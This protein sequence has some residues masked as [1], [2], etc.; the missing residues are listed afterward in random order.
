ML[1]LNGLALDDQNAELEE[2][3]KEW[4]QA[5][6][7]LKLTLTNKSEIL[8]VRE[9]KTFAE[10][11]VFIS[12]HKDRGNTL[13]QDGQY[14]AAVAEYTESLGVL[15]WFYLPNGKHSEEIPLFSGYKEFESAEDVALAQESLQVILLNIAHCLNKLCSWEASIYA[16]TYTLRLDRDNI[17]ALYRRAVAYYGQG[18]SYTLDQAVEDLLQANSIDPEDKQ[19]A[20]LLSK[21]F[22]EKVQQDRYVVRFKLQVRYKLV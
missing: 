17:K 4:R 6:D 20:K 7:F 18:T 3:R 11:L 10:R 21:Y 12:Q 16:C 2:K 14:E 22:K 5:P 8:A 13:C 15:L 9:K 19:V 1:G